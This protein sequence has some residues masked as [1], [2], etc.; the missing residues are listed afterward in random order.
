[1]WCVIVANSS[2]IEAKAHGGRSLWRVCGSEAVLAIAS[3]HDHENSY[4]KESR[5]F[6]YFAPFRGKEFSVKD[7]KSQF[8]PLQ[9]NLFFLKKDF[10]QLFCL[11]LL[12]A[13]IDF[14]TLQ[15]C[16]KKLYGVRYGIFCWTKST[17]KSKIIGSLTI[18]RNRHN[19]TFIMERKLNGITTKTEYWPTKQSQQI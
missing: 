17:N 11:S 12:F 10:A 14:T 5:I 18:R 19:I 9:S 6:C 4:P 2:K 16:I 8:N 15:F 7:W 13:I 1:M 3:N